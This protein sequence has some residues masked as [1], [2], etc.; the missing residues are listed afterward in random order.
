MFNPQ[1]IN[2]SFLKIIFIKKFNS[3][4]DNLCHLTFKDNLH[5]LNFSDLQ[6]AKTVYEQLAQYNLNWTRKLNGK[7]IEIIQTGFTTEN[8]KQIE[9]ILKDF[10]YQQKISY[11]AK[12]N[13]VL[14]TQ[15]E[16]KKKIDDEIKELD[17]YSQNLIK[18][19]KA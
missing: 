7:T 6:T 18:Q 3:S 9:L 16:A 2:E 15:K 11:Q 14:K 5:L 8:R 12:R 19:F 4:L 13:K 1:H 10:F 17:T